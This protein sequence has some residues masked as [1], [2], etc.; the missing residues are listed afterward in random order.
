MPVKLTRWRRILALASLTASLLVMAPAA[1]QAAA[2]PNPGV[3]PPN[4]HAFG[5][6]YGAW[7]AAWWQYVLAQPASSNP[8]LDPTGA[9]C[10]VGQS[11]NVFF[12]VGTTSGTVTRNDCTLPAGKALFFPLVNIYVDDS[13]PVIGDGSTADLHACAQALSIPATELHATIDGTSLS[14]LF[15]YRVLQ[16]IN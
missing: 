15:A 8:L 9:N 1:T 4:S 7:S 3:L 11:G 12:L 14:N 13:P 16:S 2:N 6:T 10:G 5:Q